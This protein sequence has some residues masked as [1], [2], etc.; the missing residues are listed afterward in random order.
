MCPT[1]T[2]KPARGQGECDTCRKYRQR[3]GKQRPVKLAARQGA[4]NLRRELKDGERGITDAEYREALE[5]KARRPRNDPT[6][7]LWWLYD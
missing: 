1:C 7:R 5:M 2:V 4:L 3:T 6:S